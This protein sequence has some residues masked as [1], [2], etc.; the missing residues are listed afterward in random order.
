MTWLLS[1]L[2][3]TVESLPVGIGN[4]FALATVVSTTS[5]VEVFVAASEWV[6]SPLS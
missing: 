4:G 5:E 1:L 3:S 6:N 2:P